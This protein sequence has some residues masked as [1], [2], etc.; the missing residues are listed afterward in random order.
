MMLKFSFSSH[1]GLIREND[2]GES[3]RPEGRRDPFE[4]SR[5]AGRGLPIIY[6]SWAW[7][8]CWERPAANHHEDDDGHDDD[9]GRDHDAQIAHDDDADGACLHLCIPLALPRELPIGELRY[10]RP[11]VKLKNEE[12]KEEEEED[13]DDDEEEEEEEEERR[14]MTCGMWTI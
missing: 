6:I 3:N 9:G 5:H 14:L 11:D 7:W 10:T 1:C 13:D 2:V 8:A 12:K 4:G